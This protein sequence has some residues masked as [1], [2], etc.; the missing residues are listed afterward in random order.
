MSS[1]EQLLVNA[2]VEVCRAVHAMNTQREPY[3]ET[4]RHDDSYI[5]K[6]IELAVSSLQQSN[7]KYKSKIRRAKNVL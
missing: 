5:V 4:T 2:Q 3:P 1:K 6:C 7:R